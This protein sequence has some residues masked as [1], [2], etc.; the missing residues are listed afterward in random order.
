MDKVYSSYKWEEWEIFTQHTRAAFAFGHLHDRTGVVQTSEIRAPLRQFDRIF[1]TW[2]LN[3]FIF[4]AFPPI[5]T[6]QEVRRLEARAFSRGDLAA[7]RSEL[8]VFVGVVEEVRNRLQN[9]RRI[10]VEVQSDVWKNNIF[11]EQSIELK[12]GTWNATLEGFFRL[13]RRN[14]LGF[15]D[16]GELHAIDFEQIWRRA[17]SWMSE[18]RC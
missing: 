8:V 16:D 11:D 7:G 4:V 3:S 13:W 5:F 10:L 9:Q 12:R 14:K 1:L 15:A 2:K 18:R 6:S 17:L